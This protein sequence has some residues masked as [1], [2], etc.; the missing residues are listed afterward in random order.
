MNS[1][2]IKKKAYI[3][4]EYFYLKCEYYIHHVIVKKFNKVKKT[5]KGHI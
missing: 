5:K 4:L 1:F 2:P 3:A